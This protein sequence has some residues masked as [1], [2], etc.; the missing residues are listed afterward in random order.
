[1]NRVLQISTAQGPVECQMFARFV[2]QTLLR[3]A[4]Q[5]GLQAEIISSHDSAQG[6][7]SATLQLSGQ[8]VAAFCEQQQGTWQWI[9][10]S[11]V[12]AKHPRKNW[13]IGVFLLPNAPALPD[14]DEVVFQSCRARGKGVTINQANHCAIQSC[15]ARGK[16]GQHVNTTNS[17][18]RATHVAS[19]ITVR[20]ENERSQH[21]NKKQ[22]LALL[23]QK[24][25]A[26]QAAQHAHYATAQHAQLYQVERGQPVRVFVGLNFREKE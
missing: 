19:G 11:P 6:L 21:A 7:L 10:A 1:M 2:C 9:C 17:A 26:Q 5:Q 16:G 14:N 13:Y 23:A 20:V 22:A 12:R 8:T 4:A 15:R 25:A 18:I 3:E 24:I